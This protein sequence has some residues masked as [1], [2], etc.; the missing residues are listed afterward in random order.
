MTR[1][2]VCVDS[3]ESPTDTRGAVMRDPSSLRHLTVA[4][5]LLIGAT[6][7]LPAVAQA[8]SWETEP[9]EPIP[10]PEQPPGAIALPVAEGIRTALPE[11]WVKTPS[12]ILIRN[13]SQ[14]TLTP[15]LPGAG[16][17]TSAAVVIAPGGGGILLPLDREGWQ[18]G[19]WLA[20]HGVAA[21]VLKYRVEPSP[22]GHDEFTEFF[23]ARRREVARR[24]FDAEAPP[25]PL[26]EAV[27]LS[28]AESDAQAAIQLV[29]TRAREWA[30][31]PRRVGFLGFSAGAH[32]VLR[33]VQVEAAGNPPDFIALIYPGMNRIAVPA[34]A[35]PM[36]VARAADDP[37]GTRGFGLVEAWQAAGKPVEFHL[38]ERGGHGFGFTGTPGTTSVNVAEAFLSWLESRGLIKP[39]N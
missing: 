29:R 28:E 27:P 24:Q 23:H 10:A 38:F 31:D 14:P 39:A 2:C 30:I 21:F 18:V 3:E 17:R 19:R 7:P 37:L 11:S 8:L 16:K 13:V 1:T 26:S 33:L 34:N 9:V 12:H 15:F 20:S 25:P 36:F 5:L 6:T 4:G 35:P 22:A 32:V